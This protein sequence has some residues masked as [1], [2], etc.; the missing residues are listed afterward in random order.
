MSL[1]C[2]YLAAQCQVRLG[3]WEEA[4]EMV[5][6]RGALG[7]DVGDGR[8]DGGIKVRLLASPV[9]IAA[10]LGSRSSPPRQRTSAA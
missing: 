6:R 9:L 3:K 8:S 4:L 2:R 1:A 5:G 10:N 7:T